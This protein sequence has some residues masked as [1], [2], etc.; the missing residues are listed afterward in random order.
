MQPQVDQVHGVTD[1]FWQ[2]KQD[3]LYRNRINKHITIP[4]ENF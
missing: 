1:A 3:A 4:R 2:G